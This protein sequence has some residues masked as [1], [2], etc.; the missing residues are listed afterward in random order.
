[1]AIHNRS[2]VQFL[3]ALVALAAFSFITPAFARGPVSFAPLAAE[4]QSSVVN[5]STT[6]TY[7]TN[8]RGLP[9]PDV[10][11]SSPFKEFFDQFRQYAPNDE[12]E[13]DEP[14]EARSLGSGFVI[15]ANG[16]IITNY[17][18]IEGANEIFVAF[19][20]GKRLEAKV[21]GADARMDLAV[22]KVD[23]GRDLDF[24]S[25]GNSDDVLVGDW[26]I[27]IGNPF[28]L[29]GSVSAG[30][31]SARNRDIRSGPYDNFIQTDAAI[32]QG[33]SGGPLFNMDG[34]VVGINTAIY[35]QSGGSLGIGFSIPVN[36]ARPFIDQLIEFGE[37]RRGWLG[38]QIQEVTEDIAAGLER[39]DM[40]GALV[41][42][43]EPEGPSAGIILEGDLILE[44]DGKAVTKMRDLP[45]LVAETLVGKE[46]IV[47]VLRLGEELELNVTLGRLEQ[48]N[49]FDNMDQLPPADVPID[50]QGTLGL[51]VED[52]TDELRA[53]YA[54]KMSIQG[55][56][57]TEVDAVSDGAEKG[58]RPGYTITEVNQQVINSKRDFDTIVATAVEVGR[59]VILL[60]I[61]DP[62]GAPRF[63][64][65]RLK[66]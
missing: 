5:I 7:G 3:G 24:V 16:T 31:V 57:I 18:V 4:L 26:V 15:D 29:G 48:V 36:L 63:V 56:L 22:L 43:V 11:D 60:K 12:F 40:S 33:N 14:M 17:H 59:E 49:P 19:V 53:K 9:F 44:F 25:F 61:V 54:I 58:I 1:M 27:A 52:L 38:V 8:A 13:H 62:T 2:F 42:G 50:E 34:E 65:L 46:V 66:K 28:G 55:V 51:Q 6:R 10:P 64:G 30:I 35:S 37:T 47:R 39:D 41:T 32:N 45:R 23:A 21:I 20:D